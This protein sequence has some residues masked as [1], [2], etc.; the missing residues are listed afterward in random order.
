MT[1]F[2]CPYL[3]HLSDLQ[4]N[5]SL[6]VCLSLIT[7]FVN[8]FFLHVFFHSQPTSFSI[9]TNTSLLPSSSCIQLYYSV[10]P[11]RHNTPFNT[12]DTLVFLLDLHFAL[13]SFYQKSFSFSIYLLIHPIQIILNAGPL[14]GWFFSLCSTTHTSR[15]WEMLVRIIACKVNKHTKHLEKTVCES[16]YCSGEA[17]TI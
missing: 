5:S 12:S 2:S 9:L 16:C 15:G 4:C 14:V 7:F 17:N 1:S 3:L 13:L 10:Y 8:F 11:L 6:F